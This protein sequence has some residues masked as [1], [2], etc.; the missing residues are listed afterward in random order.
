MHEWCNRKYA[1]S[2]SGNM[3]AHPT[4]E[5]SC[6]Y[7]IPVESMYTAGRIQKQRKTV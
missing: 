7:E 2:V 6:D 1:E 5:T 4:E 3:P